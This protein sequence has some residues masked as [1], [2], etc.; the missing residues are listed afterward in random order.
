MD[1]EFDMPCGCAYVVM[2][3]GVATLYFIVCSLGIDDDELAIKLKQDNRLYSN[4]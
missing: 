2:D 1:I 3:I 4:I